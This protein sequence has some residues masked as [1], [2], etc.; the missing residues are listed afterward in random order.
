MNDD[1]I[2]EAKSEQQQSSLAHIYIWQYFTANVRNHA[3]AK[4]GGAKNA[5]C[6]FSK[7]FSGCTSRAVAHIPGRPVLGQH[8]A[9]KC[10]RIVI[11]KNDDKAKE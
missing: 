8:V 3:D 6:M 7:S 11:N 9:R 5:E 2:D 4:K 10:P 1:K